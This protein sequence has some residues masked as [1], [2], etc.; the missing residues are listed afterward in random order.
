MSHYEITVLVLYILFCRNREKAAQD[1]QDVDRTFTENDDKERN[2]LEPNQANGS[3]NG[4]YAEQGVKL[5]ELTSQMTSLGRRLQSQL[6]SL[7][8]TVC[9]ETEASKEGSR[10]YEFFPP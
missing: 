5:K 2:L 1:Y 7:H 3:E 9:K 6:V 4:A 8:E 10:L